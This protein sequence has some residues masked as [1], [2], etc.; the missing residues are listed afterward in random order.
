MNRRSF[1]K[2]STALAGVAAVGPMALAT[3]APTI[4]VDMASGPSRTVVFRAVDAVIEGKMD[5]MKSVFYL[6]D[7]IIPKDT[8]L[9]VK[10]TGLY[11]G[12]AR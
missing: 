2:S 11:P 6:S 1:L 7:I 4:A 8:F 12:S 10:G 3:G 5:R 9:E